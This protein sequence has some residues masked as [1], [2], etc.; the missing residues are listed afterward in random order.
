MIKEV[1]S[2]PLDPTNFTR[3]AILSP[4]NADV[5]N[6]NEKIALQVD[7]QAHTYSSIR[8]ADTDDGQNICPIEFLNTVNFG[9]LIP[10]KLILKFGC[11]IM[12]HCDLDKA[13]GFINSTRVRITRLCPFFI[14]GTIITA[15]DHY[16]NPYLFHEW[17]C[18]QL[19]T[20]GHLRW[21]DSS[22][23]WGLLLSWQSTNL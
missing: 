13:S 10:H 5:D 17:K 21:Q 4:K 14:K 20:P 2:Y 3:W 15:G 9:G 7:G 18:L 19:K 1:F 8:A 6:L 22:F 16:G 11:I 12:V 23:L